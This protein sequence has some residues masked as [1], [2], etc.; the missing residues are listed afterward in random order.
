MKTTRGDVDAERRVTCEMFQSFRKRKEDFSRN[1]KTLLCLKHMGLMVMAGLKSDA[2]VQTLIPL[3]SVAGQVP[4]PWA[5]AFLSGKDRGG[6]SSAEVLK[7]VRGITGAWELHQHCQQDWHTHTGIEHFR[8]WGQHSGK[9]RLLN[10]CADGMDRKHSGL[11]RGVGGRLLLQDKPLYPYSPWRTG[12]PPSRGHLTMSGD[13][14]AA[15]I[16]RW[17]SRLLQRTDP[18]HRITQPKLTGRQCLKS[19]ICE[20]GISRTAVRERR[21]CACEGSKD[22]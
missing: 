6:S 19:F 16:S 21:E 4:S 18:Q 9:S 5:S 7:P 10:I 2:W 22:A 8:A 15:G 1:T 12:S 11:G 17:R 14:G 20:V 3:M 13:R